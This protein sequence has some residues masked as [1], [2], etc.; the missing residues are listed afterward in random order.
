MKSIISKILVT[1]AIVAAFS[2][3]VLAGPIHPS[4]ADTGKMGKMSKMSKMD[5]K[6]DKKKMD[7]KMSAKKMAKDTGKMG[8]M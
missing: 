2:L 4:L 7:K 5:K 6:M 1:G 3:N 8:K